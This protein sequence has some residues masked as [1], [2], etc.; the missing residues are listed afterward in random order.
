MTESTATPE[1]V[2][3]LNNIIQALIA[4]RNGLSDQLV[5]EQVKVA[6]LAS[7]IEKSQVHES[8]NEE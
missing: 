2:D 3:R 7:Q 4:Q 8:D 5:L 6:E 1:Q